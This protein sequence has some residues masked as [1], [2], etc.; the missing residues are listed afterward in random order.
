[1][2]QT[3]RRVGRAFGGKRRKGGNGR[4][5]GKDGG[6]GRQSQWKGR[7]DGILHD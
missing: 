3:L 4:A 6:L 7:V 2:E 1:M 5:P